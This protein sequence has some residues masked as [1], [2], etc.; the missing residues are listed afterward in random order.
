MTTSIKQKAQRLLVAV[1]LLAALLAPTAD[2]SSVYAATGDEGTRSTTTH[3]QTPTDDA[4]TP[5]DTIL[6]IIFHVMGNWGG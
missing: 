2:S 1:L 6:Q 4:P 3:V 5:V